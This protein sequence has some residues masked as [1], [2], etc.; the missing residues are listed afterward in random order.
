MRGHRAEPRDEAAA[1]APDFSKA[2]E[3]PPS[4]V[5]WR[6]HL[7][8]VVTAVKDQGQ[9]GSCWAFAST[10]VVETHIA[11][12]T[13]VLMEMAPQQVVSCTPTPSSMPDAGGC[14]GLNAERGLAYVSKSGIDT[15]WRYPYLSG[16]TKQTGECMGNG[17]FASRLAGITGFSSLPGYFQV[18]DGMTQGDVMKMAV[19]QHGPIAVTVAAGNWHFYAS[20][21]FDGCDTFTVNLDHAVVLMGYGEGTD[22]HQGVTHWWLVR[23][24]WGT[25]W[26]EK[27]YIRLARYPNSEPCGFAGGLQLACG[28]CG[29]LASGVYPVGGFLGH[30]PK[31]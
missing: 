2:K 18:P 28:E 10:E 13:G 31:A 24:S 21:I 23:N 3:A 15:Q 26:G 22:M 5:D 27:G 14:A 29:V 25:T 17:T 1:S 30:R 12:T 6:E 9:C 7:P 8:T 4:R 11:L 20:G 19:A 16:I